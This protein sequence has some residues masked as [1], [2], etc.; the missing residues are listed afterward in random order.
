M[1]AAVFIPPSPHDPFAKMSTSRSRAPLANIPNA[2]NSPHRSLVQSTKRPRTQ[3]NGVQ[4]E[5]EP[6]QKRQ[7][8]ERDA[9]SSQ[10]ATPKRKVP[11]STAE[12]RVFETG[13]A[14]GEPTAFQRKLAAARDAGSGYKVTK[15]HDAGAPNSI[16][17]IR[18]WQKHQRRAFPMFSFY[19]ESIPED[20]RKQFSRQVASLGAVCVFLFIRRFRSPVYP[21]LF[22]PA[23]DEAPCI[24]PKSVIITS[25]S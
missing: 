12:S 3:V 22:R 16:D 17:N 13:S 23:F 14:K 25:Q 8:V 11:T 5:N 10:N 9:V 15:N 19:F 18:Q 1:A 4:Q 21:T 6:P 2:T 20:V 24:P 7:M